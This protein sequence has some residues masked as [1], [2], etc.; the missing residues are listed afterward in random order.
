MRFYEQGTTDENIHRKIRQITKQSA[1]NTRYSVIPDYSLS[2]EEYTFF[3]RENNLEPLPDYDLKMRVYKKEALT[4]AL[5]AI[6]NIRNFEKNKSRFTHIITVSCTGLYTPG[7]DVELIAALG[8]SRNIERLAINFMGCNAAIPAL[9]QAHHICNANKHAKVLIVCVELCSI[10]FM[11]DYSED[12]LLSSSLFAD[13]CACVIV[14]KEEFIFS[15]ERVMEIKSFYSEIVENTKGE[16]AWD[17][18]SKG[19]K[20]MLKPGI[21]T[22]IKAA[23]RNYLSNA[24]FN[25]KANTGFV[26][27]P[28]GKRILDEIKKE[29]NFSEAILQTAYDVLGKY[30]NMSSPTIL[31]V[32]QREWERMEQ[33]GSNLVMVAFGPGLTIEG[34]ELRYV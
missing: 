10:H 22:H 11:K 31:F 27:H 30:G 16:M 15:M 19:F 5:D 20:M 24:P 1:I 2:K 3:S 21:P 28:G 9:K 17:V 4:L 6:K 13:G 23:I 14:E 33:H 12:Y 25:I 8:L 7:L 34:C 26:V 18:S 32:L 29:M